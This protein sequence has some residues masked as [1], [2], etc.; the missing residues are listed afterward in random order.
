MSSRNYDKANK[1]RC[2][3]FDGIRR[4]SESK[5]KNEFLFSHKSS[6]E[7]I[8]YHI[9]LSQI[10]YIA[11]KEKSL[12]NKDI[13]ETKKILSLLKNVLALMIN[14]KNKIYNYLQ[15]ENNIKFA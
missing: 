10:N 14:E 8:L 13:S 11:N 4:L 9:K 6:L 15:N 12:N 3:T 1:N 7:T 5:K 2:K